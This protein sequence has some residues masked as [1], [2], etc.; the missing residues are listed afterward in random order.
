[1][2]SRRVCVS[3]YNNTCLFRFIYSMFVLCG[4]EQTNMNDRFRSIL[5]GVRVVG[6]RASGGRVRR[7][8]RSGGLLVVRVR[9]WVCLLSF[10]WR[11][12]P[13]N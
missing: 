13:A 4:Y 8:V 10:F 3:I 1:M 12:V 5:L 2:V 6:K 11:D 9:V 7:V